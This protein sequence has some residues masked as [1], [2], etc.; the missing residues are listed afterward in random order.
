[1]AQAAITPIWHGKTPPSVPEYCLATPTEVRPFSREAG[2]VD[3]QH[4]R[5]TG[6]GAPPVVVQAAD[7]V[8]AGE[9]SQLI[10]V[11]DRTVQ[12]MLLSPRLGVT[13]VLGQLPAVL[14]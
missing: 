5:S 9:V 4:S 12:Q 1:V 14:A 13:A 6:P 7:D 8:T 10:D 3:D 2:L 11:P